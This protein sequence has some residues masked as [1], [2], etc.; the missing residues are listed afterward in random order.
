M[1]LP[2]TC[3][4]CGAPLDT[5][6]RVGGGRE[7]RCDACRLTIGQFEQPLEDTLTAQNNSIIAIRRI[8][9]GASREATQADQKA[10]QAQHVTREHEQ[11]LDSHGRMLEY[12]AKDRHA[13]VERVER[14]EEMARLPLMVAPPQYTPERLEQTLQWGTPPSGFIVQPERATPPTKGEIRWKGIIRSL[15]TSVAE[16]NERIRHLEDKIAKQKRAARFDQALI[17]EWK[18]DC[19]AAIRMAREE[20]DK[21]EGLHSQ[22][23]AQA[24]TIKHAIEGG[25]LR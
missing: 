20:H 10:N 14:L 1:T 4:K 13:L 6:V 23:R 22:V 18:D 8:A 25:Y 9:D 3:P 24:W 21:V 17:K 16:K 2:T 5:V 12:A 15:E 11:R 19:E 7:A